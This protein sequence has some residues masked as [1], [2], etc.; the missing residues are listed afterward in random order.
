MQQIALLGT[1]NEI[2]RQHSGGRNAQA[3]DLSLYYCGDRL[4]LLILA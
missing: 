2:A 4:L 3:H 1:P